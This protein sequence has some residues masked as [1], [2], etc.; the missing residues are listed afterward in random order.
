MNKLAIKRTDFDKAL[1]RVQDYSNTLPDNPQF[2]KFETEGW[3]FG[4][5]D[6]HVSGYE[7][8]GFIE[9]L[10]ERLTIVNRVFHGIIKEFAGVYQVFD[11]LDKEY[12]AGILNSLKEA[13]QAIVVAQKAC[14]G[15]TVTLEQLRKTVEKLLQVSNDLSVFKEECT[16]KLNRLE[17]KLLVLDKFSKDIAQLQSHQNSFKKQYEEVSELIVFKQNIID[18]INLLQAYIN[19]HDLRLQNLSNKQTKD[20]S[21]IESQLEQKEQAIMSW[22]EE[23]LT[24]QAFYRK[25]MIVAYVISVVSMVLSIVSICLSVM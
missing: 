7:M 8:N 9:K 10:Q 1:K 4:L 17:Q 22:I 11:A 19:D 23:L 13:H 3:F 24:K 6:H 14:D 21:R 20:T 12:V 18:D 15:N 25:R 2:E 5:N 16:R